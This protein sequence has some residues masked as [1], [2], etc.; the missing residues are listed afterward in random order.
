MANEWKNTGTKVSMTPKG[1]WV[2]NTAYRVLDLVH[3]SDKTIFYIAKKDVPSGTALS[4]T[5]Y[6]DIV[7]DV[8]DIPEQVSDLKSAVS[9][10]ETQI[11]SFLTQE[12]TVFKAVWE[13]GQIKNGAD[14]SGPN[15]RRTK[16]YIPTYGMSV[17]I[18]GESGRGIA[19]YAVEYDKD[20]NY[21]A[22]NSGKSSYILPTHPECKYV[23]AMTYSTTVP[24]AE[25]DQ[26]VSIEVINSESIGSLEE[27]INN[28]KTELKNTIDAGIAYLGEHTFQLYPIKVYSMHQESTKGAIDAKNKLLDVDIPTGT[29]YDV[30]LDYGFDSY[31]RVYI[32]E[33]EEN[34]TTHNVNFI[35]NGEKK[36]ITASYDVKGI[37][38]FAGTS[39]IPIGTELS[40]SVFVMSEESSGSLEER[41]VEQKEEQRKLNNEI[42]SML[43]I[44]DGAINRLIGEELSPGLIS[45]SGAINN[46]TSTTTKYTKNA[47]HVIPGHKYSFV[48]RKPI[49]AEESN[50]FAYATYTDEDVF[51]ARIEPIREET[52]KDGYVTVVS[53]FIV[54]DGVNY[55]RLSMITGA[56]DF[57]IALL[58]NLGDVFA[59]KTNISEVYDSLI[60]GII[61]IAIFATFT[62]S[63][64]LGSNGVIQGGSRWA[65]CENELL[66]VSPGD[67]LQYYGKTTSTNNGETFSQWWAYGTY[68]LSENF[69]S[70]I[71][72]SGGQ[73]VD[74]YYVIDKEITVPDGVYFI[75]LTYNAGDEEE[76]IINKS[77]NQSKTDE[78]NVPY[79]YF[80]D[81]YL[82][83]KVTRIETIAKEDAANGDAF[84]FITDQ[85][86]NINERHSPDLIKYISQR[87]NIPRCFNGGDISDYGV[88]VN[89]VLAT[90]DYTT[91]LRR[92][93]DGEIYHAVGN[94]EYFNQATGSDLYYWMDMF[95][96]NQI[97][98][99]D[100]HYWYVDNPQKKLRYI[101]LSAFQH[102]DSSPYVT[103]GYEQEQVNWLR[104]VALNME[105]G[106]GALIFTHYLRG[107]TTLSSS[108][109]NV[110]DQYSGNGEIIAVIG[111]HTHW[112]Y[113]T[114]T[115][116][117]V[118]VISVTC[119][120][121]QPWIS[122]G[123]NMEPWMSDR[124]AGTIKEQAFDVFVLN[125][126][127]KTLTQIRIGCP[128]RD[129]TD[130]E[131]WTE[132]E[133]VTTSYARN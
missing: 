49:V 99:N 40:L 33:I 36:R 83:N 84:F 59:S 95:N 110:I 78:S 68:D 127:N 44:F 121:N 27:G 82:N 53:E 46:Q 108:I 7:T 90:K 42:Q 100:R 77:I 123:E 93:F 28:N 15:N 117:G 37:S 80:T 105:S 98:N 91:R 72:L 4:N 94:H 88:T 132:Q 54:P 24:Q 129:G 29:K 107:K 3:N 96:T 6:W 48:L 34:G 102:M 58:F 52:Q 85:H 5:E 13:N 133:E 116:G 39:I 119:D 55:I 120:K 65:R 18:S 60:H 51:I 32:Y 128:I 8:S 74:G 115:P 69:V 9:P 67:T 11:G 57:K 106:W 76:I 41:M 12:N 38:L 71:V 61:N 22:F 75:R 64:F 23:R 45:I 97:G 62:K 79:Y 2:S 113:H 73:E 125:R 92:A 1:E 103:T 25:Q 131:T 118:P 31:D 35:T 26:Y 47:I 104:D 87:C 70:R 20:K 66:P 10:I 109:E 130:P 126:T 114:A 17:K 124:I 50:W 19:Y 112:D 122:S 89:G 86:W 63:K 81:N 16:T 101:I 56:L 43:D 30:Q 14:E 21:L 111:G